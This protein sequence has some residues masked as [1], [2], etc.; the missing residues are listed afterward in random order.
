MQRQDFK[1]YLHT[2]RK[3]KETIPEVNKKNKFSFT[4]SS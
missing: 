1:K 3:T 2:N 4:R